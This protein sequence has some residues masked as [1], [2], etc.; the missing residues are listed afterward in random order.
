MTARHTMYVGMISEQIG[1]K[2]I[3]AMLALRRAQKFR[4]CPCSRKEEMA[5]INYNLY[6][7]VLD[8]LEYSA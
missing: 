4:T 1:S 8:G 6:C 5:M 3:H 2:C 7:Q